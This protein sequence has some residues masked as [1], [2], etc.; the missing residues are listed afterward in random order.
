MSTAWVNHDI[1]A[2]ESI[3]GTEPRLMTQSPAVRIAFDVLSR[4]FTMVQGLWKTKR[5]QKHLRVCESVSLGDKRFVAVI[6]V[7]QERFLVGGA[8]NSVAML[9]RLAEPSSFSST[10]KELTEA[11]PEIQ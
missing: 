9:S 8:A 10:M 1:D 2:S 11:G 7:D 3:N 5:A 4:L 6:Q